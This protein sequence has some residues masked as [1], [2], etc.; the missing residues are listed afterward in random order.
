[1][2]TIKA[3]APLGDTV[4]VAASGTPAAGVQVPSEEQNENTRSFQ[5]YHAG[6]DPLHLG[7][8]ATAAEAQTNAV[9]PVAGTP[10]KVISLP[11]GSVAC[12]SL[13]K[14]TFFSALSASAGSVFITPGVGF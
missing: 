10:Q 11:G 14:D 13:G 12:F 8:G 9:A 4:L 2:K 5:V 7:Y 6:T 3:F 1:M